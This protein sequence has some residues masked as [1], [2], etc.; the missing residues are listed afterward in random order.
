[1]VY[2]QHFI[3]LWC[4]GNKV[5]LEDQ[6]NLNIRFNNVLID[7]TKIS[8]SQG[9]YSFEF[10]VPCTPHNNVIFDYANNLSKTNKFHQRYNA[11]VYADG[12]TVFSGSITLNGVKDNR[13]S[14][15]LVS[16]KVYSLDEIF[17]DMTMDKIKNFKIDFDGSQTINYLNN[18]TNP[19]ACFPFVSYGAFQK[20]PYSEE[21]GINAYTSK[22][23]IDE[24]NRW[25]VESFP[26]SHNML[27]TLRK[28]FESV[29]YKVGGDVFSDNSLKKVYMSVNLADG[30][31]PD[32]NVGN[33]R[34]GKVDIS[35]TLTTSGSGYEQELQYP[36][37]KVYA[38]GQ[39]DESEGITSQTEYNYSS[40][41]MYD[42][43]G[44]SGVTVNNTPN[45]MYQP[46]EGVIIAPVSGFYKIEM[47]VNSTLNT[48]GTIRAKQ[49]LQNMI[50]R[51]MYEED[52]DMTAGFTEITPIEVALIRNYDDNY[53][54]IKG[55]NNRKYI[56]GNPN[57]E[58]YYISGRLRENIVDWQTCFPHEDPY[59]S[60]LPTEAGDL[61]TKNSQSRR[62]GLR[63]SGGGN[64]SSGNYTTSASGN[65]SGRR[66]GT[67]GGTIDP[68][69]GGRQYSP[70]KYG[71]V[72][73]DRE[74]M[75]YDQIVSNTFICG[76][77]SMSGG[78]PAVMKNGYSWSPLTA[79]KNEIFAPVI[80]YSMLSRE[81]GTGNLV[82][83]QT[84]HNQNSYI[85]TPISY[86]NVSRNSMNGYVSCMVWLNK[87]DIL[88]LVAVH[89]NHERENGNAVNYS[90]TT[91]VNLKIQAFSDRSYD[92]LK[93]T[94]DNR[95]EAPVEFDTQLNLANFF[96]KEKKV[97]EW[98]Q[99]IADAFNLDIIQDGK[100]VTIN[101][102][103]KLTQSTISTI[104]IDD[105]VNSADAESASIDYPRSMAVKYKI[106]IDEWGFERSAVE[107]A[108]GDE[109]ILN[110]DDWVKYG[111]SGFSIVQL[112]DD[113]YAT[114]TSD[115]SLQF[116]YTWY[117]NFN[118]YAVD[119]SFN[120]TSNTPVTLRIPCISKYS[121]M[122]DGYS[123]EESMKHDGFGQAQRFWFKPDPTSSYVWTRTYPAEQIM[124]HKPKNLDAINLSYKD[125]EKSLLSQYFNFSAF[126]ASN[127]I[128]VEVYLNPEEYNAI[129]NG[130]LVHFDSDI[131]IP[132]EISGYDPT[133]NNP[134]ELKLMKKVN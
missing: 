126:L 99:N 104:D 15:N 132:V 36:Y 68:T 113:M 63:T 92:M 80:G 120:K 134:T 11:E 35:T 37:Y 121:Y 32:Y 30:Q 51:E 96:N 118:W 71:Y 76:L 4:N 91:S 18:Q 73:N 90:T 100:T 93:A 88:R 24:W 94:H 109:S 45:Y 108:G 1:M 117:Q 21:G 114:S 111:D 86:C 40:I 107:A 102:R 123:Y 85:N 82:Y 14:L 122:I 81:A 129:K 106:D 74:I 56:N 79:E 133:C 83:E 62:G 124:L 128:T 64:T 33:P 75:C 13:Y 46:N 23:D 72:Y 97:S 60:E 29:D 20:S 27:K 77:S 50:S 28:A 42:L 3:E 12:Y 54:L 115:K 103:K 25:Y 53:E 41:N 17:G 78:V 95:Y 9:E 49:W 70:L 110:N 43:L 105:R 7:P 39:G 34:F 87:D 6:K 69:G 65:F 84:E 47:T 26:P 98:V 52:V 112:N 127:Y 44:H 38:V 2:K 48:T 66:G 5:E 57:D 61:T 31:S 101:S 10:E 22:F 59:A 16:I 55:K 19:D 58:Y 131:Y 125:S 116:S 130:S 67:R 8:S 89:R 119:S